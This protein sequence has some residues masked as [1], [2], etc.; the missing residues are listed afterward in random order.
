ME[1]M[2]KKLCN[3]IVLGATGM[4]GSMVEKVLSRDNNFFVVGTQFDDPTA[5][6]Y[7]N[8]LN[9]VETLGRVVGSPPSQGGVEGGFLYFINCIGITANLVREN[10]PASMR[11]AILV[12][13]IFPQELAMFAATH[14][15]RVIHMS[16]DGVFASDASEADEQHPH[17]CTDAYG[18]TKS[19]GE[20]VADHVLNIRTSIIG[21]SPVVGGGMF[22]WF[23]SQP[24]GA[25]ISGYTDHFWNGVTTRQFAEFCGWI[26]REDMFSR[27][28]TEGPAVHYVPNATVTKYD[29]LQLFRTVIKKNIIINPIESPKGSLMR[30]LHSTSSVVR[31]YCSNILPMQKAIEAMLV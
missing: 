3:V 21:P 24:D 13:S 14:N 23:R 18:K 26:I 8:V 7:F 29:L 27:L 20:A 12:N 2:E 6:Y 30:T 25:T 17:D 19:L 15:A 11:R 28:R 10:D 4:L 22:E 31:E 9:G 1:K 5:P 16:T